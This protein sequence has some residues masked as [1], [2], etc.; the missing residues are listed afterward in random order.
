[1]IGT[2]E[3]FSY[4]VPKGTGKVDIRYWSDDDFSITVAPR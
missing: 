2:H 3:S 1:V 4:I